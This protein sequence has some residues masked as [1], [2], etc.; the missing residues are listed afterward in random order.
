M[1]AD[2]R[3]GVALYIM[4]LTTLVPTIIHVFSGL[5]ALFTQKA[6]MLQPV[7]AELSEQPATEAFSAASVGRL[8]RKIRRASILGNLAACMAVAVLFIPP[9]WVVYALIT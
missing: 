9:I 7:V 4:A 6:W 5:A 8:E 1:H 3:T 2:P